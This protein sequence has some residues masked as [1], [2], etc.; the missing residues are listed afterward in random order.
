MHALFRC[1]CFYRSFS[2]NFVNW[3]FFIIRF[4]SD[5]WQKNA[6]SNVIT[7]SLLSACEENSLGYWLLSSFLSLLSYGSSSFPETCDLVLLTPQ[8]L[9]DIC[10]KHV[11]VKIGF[12][13]L[14]TAEDVPDL[15]VCL[16]TFLL[17]ISTLL[18][19]IFTKNNKT[20]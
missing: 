17:K 9:F 18:L 1:T 5:R 12:A 2:V 20:C 19:A 4:Q 16:Y 10:K 8:I 15:N 14:T 13:L 3:C 11:L 6:F 7:C